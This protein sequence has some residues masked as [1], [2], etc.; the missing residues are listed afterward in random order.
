MKGA[1]HRAGPAVSPLPSR[2]PHQQPLL[3]LSHLPSLPPHAPELVPRL[4]GLVD[5]TVV[6][7]PLV[8]CLLAQGLV[9]LELQDKTHKVPAGTRGESAGDGG[10]PLPRN[11]PAPHR[12]GQRPDQGLPAAKGE[13]NLAQ[14]GGPLEFQERMW[15]QALGMRGPVS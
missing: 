6:Q 2:R 12:G 10:G 4:G 15:G 3:S 8:A 5:V 11:Q 1:L 7:W 14:E 13:P 9:E